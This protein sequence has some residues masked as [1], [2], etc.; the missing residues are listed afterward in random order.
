[1]SVACRDESDVQF[2]GSDRGLASGANVTA[3]LLSRVQF[4]PRRPD[5]CS[6]TPDE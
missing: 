4:P 1:M 3:T 2:D 5:P 6:V